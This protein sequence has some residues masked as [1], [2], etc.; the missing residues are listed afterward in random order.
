VCAGFPGFPFPC[1]RDIDLVFSHSS[2]PSPP[3]VA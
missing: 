1:Y 3:T 2:S